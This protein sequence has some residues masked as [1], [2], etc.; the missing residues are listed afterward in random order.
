M[1]NLRMFILYAV[2]E[3]EVTKS[4][5]R[6]WVWRILANI[7]I[8]YVYIYML[9]ICDASWGWKSVLGNKR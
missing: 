8:K 9:E 5:E 1:R 2:R 4:W 7:S 3:V 6:D